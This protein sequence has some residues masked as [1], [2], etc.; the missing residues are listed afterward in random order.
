MHTHSDVTPDTYPRLEIRALEAKKEQF[1]LFILGWKAIMTPGYEP[2]AAQ[3][4]QQGQLSV[5]LDKIRA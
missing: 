5:H 4:V 1:T 2:V 3:F